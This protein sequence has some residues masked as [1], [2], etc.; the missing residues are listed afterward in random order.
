[1]TFALGMTKILGR[2]LDSVAVYDAGITKK[3][4]PCRRRKCVVVGLDN[5][6]KSLRGMGDEL[7]RGMTECYGFLEYVV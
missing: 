1:M 2:K 5:I 6:E 7:A 4:L 3:S